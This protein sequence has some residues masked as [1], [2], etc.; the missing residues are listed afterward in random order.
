MD[1]RDDFNLLESYARSIVVVGMTNSRVHRSNTS[2]YRCQCFS[3]TRVVI[4]YEL[5]KKPWQLLHVRT[6]SSVIICNVR[7]MCQKSWWSDRNQVVRNSRYSFIFVLAFIFDWR[8]INAQHTCASS[9]RLNREKC[10]IRSNV[11]ITRCTANFEYSD[12]TVRHNNVYMLVTIWICRVNNA[13]EILGISIMTRF[14][15]E[16]RSIFEKRCVFHWIIARADWNMEQNLSNPRILR[17]RI[18]LFETWFCLPDIIIASL[19]LG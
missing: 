19:I 12:P 5:K 2:K 13:L 8:L 9:P 15:T 10:K 7:K 17:D 14:R 4:S 1:I 6:S 3:S 18:I 16:V 11:L